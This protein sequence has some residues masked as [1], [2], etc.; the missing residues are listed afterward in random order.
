M[1]CLGFR[2]TRIYV[3]PDLQYHPL[4]IHPKIKEISYIWIFDIHAD[5]KEINPGSMNAHAV[6]LPDK[7]QDS[8]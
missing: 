3:P 8:S 1:R 2:R 6:G 5:Y 7:K 4:Y